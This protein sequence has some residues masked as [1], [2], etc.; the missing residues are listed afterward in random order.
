MK[1]N[2]DNDTTENSQLLFMYDHCGVYI[3]S[4]NLYVTQ[5]WDGEEWKQMYGI[6]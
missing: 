1:D 2:G 5:V 3:L 4:H 6:T